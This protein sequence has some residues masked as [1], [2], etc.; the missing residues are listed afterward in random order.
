MNI[1]TLACISPPM[2]GGDNMSTGV[3]ECDVSEWHKFVIAIVFPE[4]GDWWG[5]V[6]R[7]WCCIFTHVQPYC[8]SLMFTTWGGNP[9][10]TITQ[11]TSV[12]S[13]CVVRHGW[14][15]NCISWQKCHW[16]NY[17][18]VTIISTLCWT[19]CGPVPGAQR[20]V[21]IIVTNYHDN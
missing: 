11:Y 21:A 18:I 4:P 7:Y 20:R 10:Q 1:I 3:H 9:W 2:T 8:P 5:T 15:Q 12:L 17:R 16:S 14:L 19:S 13:D 6:T